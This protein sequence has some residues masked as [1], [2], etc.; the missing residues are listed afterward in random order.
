[1]QRKTTII[2]CILLLMASKS[3]SQQSLNTHYVDQ[4]TY[5]LFLDHQWDDLI[6]L[7][8]QSLSSGIDFYYLR[9]RM[10]IAYYN[11]SNFH[12]ALPH[13]NKAYIENPNDPTLK[14]YIYFANLF[15]NRRKEARLI[16]GSMGRKQRNRLSIDSDLWVESI[17]IHY[18][19]SEGDISESTDLGNFELD[20]AID[21]NQFISKK[22]RFFGVFL[23]HPV[24]SRFSIYHGYSHTNKNHFVYNQLDGD[25]N[26]EPSRTSRLNQYYISGIIRLARNLNLIAGAHFI[27]IRYPFEVS[28]S[29]GANTFTAIQTITSNNYVGFI[30]MYKYLPLI[31]IGG[32]V[33]YAGLNDEK[34]L[35]TDIMLSWYPLGN[36]NVYAVSTL[37]FQSEQNQLNAQTHRQVFFQQ[38]GGKITNNLWLE[39]FGSTGDMKNF[40]RNDAVVVYNA[41]DMVRQQVG[42]NVTFS[43]SKKLNTSLRYT[44]SQNR[45]VFNPSSPSGTALNTINYN[46]HSITGGLAWIF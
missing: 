31:T 23:S 36:L 26:T 15:I 27:N 41:M 11:K 6:R 4:Q 9:Y 20:P 34:Q 21:G 10:G 18:N 40:L 25:I 5:A 46:S 16:A 28:I 2:I 14:E 12:Q 44:F 35:Q 7:G 33:Y 45:S 38:L 22:H 13:L 3:F 29:R 43:L 19:A 1:M 39:V 42:A 30:S 8:K 37:S 17:E 32:S 24:N